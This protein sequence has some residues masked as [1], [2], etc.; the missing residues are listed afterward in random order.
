MEKRLELLKRELTI[1]SIKLSRIP[2]ISEESILTE[3]DICLNPHVHEGQVA[4]YGATF[5]M[6]PLP[7]STSV[8]LVSFEDNK[9]DDNRRFA[10]GRRSFLFHYPQAK[11]QLGILDSA[12]GDEFRLLQLSSMISGIVLQRQQTGLVKIV[13]QGNIH[14]SRG[15]IWSYKGSTSQAYS[16]IT[17]CLENVMTPNLAETIMGLLRISYYSLSPE[18]IG[19]TL[20]CRLADAGSTV[21]GIGLN[22]LGISVQD[23]NSYSLVSHI[24][25]YQDGATFVLPTGEFEAT[26]VHLGYSVEAA[27]NVP[28][29]GGTRHTSAARFTFDHPDMIAFVVSQDGPVT[30]FSDG[31]NVAELPIEGALREVQ[32]LKKVS[33][34]SKKRDISGDSF[35]LLCKSCGRNIRIEEVVILGWKDREQVNCPICKKKLYS[36]MCF[37]LKAYPIK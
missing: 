4:P 17:A 16:G 27:A 7:E 29:I 11:P 6:T 33:P 26:G 8:K 2:G 28:E 1:D 5:C 12:F 18:G 34:S 23:V 13:Q 25:R 30:I 22:S 31:A 3:L 19:A 15:R 24:L 20:V 37:S 10:D 32:W 36:S 21:G 14:I 9:I 35:V